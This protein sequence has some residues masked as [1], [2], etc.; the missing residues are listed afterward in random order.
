[1]KTVERKRLCAPRFELQDVTNER[2]RW[3]THDTRMCIA[4]RRNVFFFPSLPIDV[5]RRCTHIISRRIR[6]MGNAGA[7]RKN[8]VAAQQC[9]LAYLTHYAN[10]GG[11]K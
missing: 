4:S 8:L 6:I 11:L 5:L 7:G 9:A 2:A 1:M 3:A 10:G